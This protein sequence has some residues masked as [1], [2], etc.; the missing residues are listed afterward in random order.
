MPFPANQSDVQ[1]NC[2]MTMMGRTNLD[3]F[4][5]ANLRE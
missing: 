4:I 3:C 5:I 1:Q 2:E